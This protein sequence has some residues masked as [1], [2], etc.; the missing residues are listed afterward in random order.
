MNTT[1]RSFYAIR[2]V[3]SFARQP[4]RYVGI[5][6]WALLFPKAVLA[7]RLLAA[8]SQLAT[9]RERIRDKKD[10]RPRFTPAFRLLWI[11]L[12]KVLDGWEQLAQLMQPATVK[13]WHTTAFRLYW[14]WKSKPG[15]PAISREMQLLIRQLSKDNPLWGVR[16]FCREV[17]L[18]GPS[19]RPDAIQHAPYSRTLRIE[20]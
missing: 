7:A 5:F 14:R 6:L 4:L 13:K 3:L 15:R 18:S 8:E 19:A 12:S 20:L 1:G 2:R 10:P 17:L 9:C 16:R 11:V